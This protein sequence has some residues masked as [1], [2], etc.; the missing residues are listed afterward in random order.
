MADVCTSY[1]YLL[2]AEDA[3][4]VALAGIGY[5]FLT[6]RVREVSTDAAWAVAIAGGLLVIGSFVA[7][8]LRKIIVE[9]S[10]ETSCY[11]S[12][13]RPFFAII[14]PA[15]AILMW[16]AWCI[17]ANRKISFWPF[18]VLLVLG[19]VGALA[20]ADGAAP[21]DNTNLPLLAAA[22]LWSV[23][24]GVVGAII[25]SR[26]GDRLSTVL[27]SVYAF[28]I[29]ALPGLGSRSNVSDVVNQWTAQGV[30]TVAQLCFVIACYRLWT[31]YQRRST[32]PTP[33]EVLT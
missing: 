16:G 25:S 32:S 1:S 3:V 24:L 17:M 19:V 20:Y 21:D 7:G 13:Q 33:S 31:I 5:Y 23:G 11:L 29:L 30:N 15:F 27:F 9:A 22:G 2:A 28:A 18:F 12:L 26:Q 8:V 10:G 4:P 14:G 6:K